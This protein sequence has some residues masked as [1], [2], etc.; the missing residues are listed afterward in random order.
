[1]LRWEVK[2][3]EGNAYDKGSFIHSESMMELYNNRND[4]AIV[5]FWDGYAKASLVE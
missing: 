4:G 2:I 5:W 3:P 1:M